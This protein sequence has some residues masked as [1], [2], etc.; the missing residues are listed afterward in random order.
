MREVIATV[1]STPTS[2]SRR[3]QDRNEDDEDEEDEEDDDDDVVMRE[4]REEK[5]KWEAIKKAQIGRSDNHEGF[6]FLILYIRWRNY[7]RHG[8]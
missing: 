1:Q 8:T 7:T 5:K 4:R 3:S 2:V 6:F